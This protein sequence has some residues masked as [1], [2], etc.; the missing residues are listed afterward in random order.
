M[1]SK[2]FEYLWQIAMAV[3]GGL[4]GFLHMLQREEVKSMKDAITAAQ[5][6]ADASQRA[7][8]AH[9]LYAAETY[10]RK[11]DVDKA[12]EG[13]ERRIKEQLREHQ[14]AQLTV[15]QEIRDRLPRRN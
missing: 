9:K 13:A 3:G 1:D 5:D 7:L 11:A 12:V 15:L 2:Q 14:A 10:A 4:L 6:D 8:E